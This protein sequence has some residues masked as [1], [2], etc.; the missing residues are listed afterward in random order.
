MDLMLGNAHK[1]TGNSGM[2]ILTLSS[3]MLR[4]YGES[5][6]QRSACWSS[7]SGRVINSTSTRNPSPID[8]ANASNTASTANINTSNTKTIVVPKRISLWDLRCEFK[9][10]VEC[11]RNVRVSNRCDKNKCGR[12]GVQRASCRAG[13]GF[14]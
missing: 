14:A 4:L 7:S 2:G 3:T 13:C 6:Y 1:L 8:T 10:S 5:S 9:G 12:R 11:S